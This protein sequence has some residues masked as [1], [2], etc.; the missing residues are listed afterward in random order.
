MLIS[1][2]NSRRWHTDGSALLVSFIDIRKTY[3]NATP[4]RNLCLAFPK[5]LRNPRGY[6]GHLLRCVRGT[7]CWTALRRML[8][9]HYSRTWFQERCG[10]TVRL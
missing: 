1:D 5:E 8:W 7:R 10:V 9:Q 2:F 6:C 4:A 3:V